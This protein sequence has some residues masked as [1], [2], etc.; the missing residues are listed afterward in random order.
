MFNST[1]NNIATMTWWSVLLV[2]DKK[3]QKRSINL[4][5]YVGLERL[6]FRKETV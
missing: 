4:V 6:S 3:C 2:E 5:I 1:F